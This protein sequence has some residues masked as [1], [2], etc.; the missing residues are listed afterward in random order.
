MTGMKSL[1]DRLSAH[2]NEVHV[3]APGE[4]RNLVGRVSLDQMM[5]EAHSLDAGRHALQQLS[6]GSIGRSKTRSGA[7]S[8]RVL[9]D[10]HDKQLCV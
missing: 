8:G 5:L 7:A 2:D 10:M 6:Y 3:V 1:D 4:V 9:V